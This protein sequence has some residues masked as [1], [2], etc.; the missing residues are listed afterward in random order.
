LLASYTLSN[1]MDLLDALIAA[2]ALEHDYTLVT[3]NRK[4]FAQVSGLRVITPTA[5]ST[6]DKT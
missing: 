5:I 6:D 2:I 4:H 1:G 3:L